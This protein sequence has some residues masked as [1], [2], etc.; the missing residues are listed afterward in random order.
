MS[1]TTAARVAGFTFLFYI[2]IGLSSM[3]GAFHGPAAQFASYAQNA[4]AVILGLS[5][6]LVTRVEWPVVAMIGMAFRIAEG[7]RGP[8]LG[9]A[10][11]SLSHPALVDA[12]LFAVGSTCFCWL[13]LRGRMIPRV[14]AWLGLVASLILVVGLPLQLADLLPAPLAAAMWMPMLAFE[15]PTGAWLLAKGVAEP[16]RPA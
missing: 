2:V 1:R 13:L 9:A 5:L 7:A 10:G 14:L 12:T 11:I 8:V 15:I 3:A 4:S 16:N 6:F